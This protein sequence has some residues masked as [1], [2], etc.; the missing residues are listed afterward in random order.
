MVPITSQ[1]PLFP[2]KRSLPYRIMVEKRLEKPRFS[3][4]SLAYHSLF[5][6]TT[7]LHSVKDPASAVDSQDPLTRDHDIRYLHTE[8]DTLEAW[9]W[10]ETGRTRFEVSKQCLRCRSFLFVI[11]F[12]W[13][14]GQD[15]AI[16][17][18]SRV[19]PRKLC[20]CCIY[21][22]FF[23]TIYILPF[24]AIHGLLSKVLCM[25]LYC[26]YSYVRRR[27]KPPRQVP[28]VIGSATHLTAWN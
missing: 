15:G 10:A 14:A 21:S 2:P 5:P 24:I 26:M 25:S 20:F 28:T 18:V 3:G 12:S 7:S 16:T 27:D 23:N 17:S 9:T 8:C 19:H 4:R 11:F 6:K 1:D 22:V 13:Q